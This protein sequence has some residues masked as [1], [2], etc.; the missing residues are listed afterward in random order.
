MPWLARRDDARPVADPDVDGA[1]ADERD[2]VRVDL[3]LELDVEAA[4]R[5]VALLLGE[6]EL[7]EL[8][9][10]DVAEPDDQLGRRD[11]RVGRLGAGAIAHG[12]VRRRR[13]RRS[14]HRRRHRPRRGTPMTARTRTR[15]AGRG[16]GDDTRTSIRL[17]RAWVSGPRR[18]GV[19]R[20]R[21][22]GR[23]RRPRGRWSRAWRTS[24]GCR[25]ATRGRG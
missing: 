19:R 7:R 3:V 9:A 25:T 17:A 10:R 4:V 6:V 20:R 21:R 15:L 23:G 1:R 22:R 13:T 16:R 12:G 2:E 11:A 24:T 8:D 18:A 5:V 14:P